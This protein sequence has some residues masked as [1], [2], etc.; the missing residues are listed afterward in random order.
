MNLQKVLEKRASI[1]KYSDKKV[2][3]E[4]IIEAIEAAHIAPSPGNLCMLRYIV[5]EN[6]GL[7]EKIAE[8]CQQDFVK[9]APFVVIVCSDPS[10]AKKFYDIRAKQYVKHHV[11]ASVENFLLKITDLGLASCWVGAFSEGIKSLLKIP[12]NIDVEVILPVGYQAV[13]DKRKQKPK[14]S[15]NRKIFFEK[16]GNKFGEPFEMIR[17][18]DV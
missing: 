15:L 7:K 5:V 16:W 1:R 3:P 14:S 11:G 17:R 9:D 12:D 8:S 6:Q 4:L 18:G 10:P 2:K 13:T